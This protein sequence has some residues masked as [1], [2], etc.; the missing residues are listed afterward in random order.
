MA[1]GFAHEIRNPLTSIKTFLQLISKRKDDPEFMQR[2]MG[3]VNGDI[4]RIERLIKEILN[5]STYMNPILRQE[6]INATVTSCLHYAQVKA[7]QQAIQVQVDL[8]ED[9]PSV[10]M[11]GH[12]IA[13]VLVN[14]L[15]NAVEAMS[16]GPGWLLIQTHRVAKESETWIQIEISDTGCGIKPE[17]LD[18]IFDPF[19]TTKH[20]RQEWEGT[21]LGLTIVDQIVRQHGGYIEVSSHIGQGATFVINIPSDPR[22]MIPTVAVSF[23]AKE[24]DCV[25]PR[26]VLETPIHQ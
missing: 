10:W 24:T 8:A 15:L 23:A 22:S 5:C 20:H 6:N 4:A 1:G 14:I 12:Q 9:L 21:G 16:P 11:D 3:T 13:Q 2:F 7:E 26:S 17:D 18:H 19:F 25:K